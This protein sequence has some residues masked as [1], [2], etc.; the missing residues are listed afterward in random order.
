MPRSFDTPL[1]IDAVLEDLSRTLDQ[2]NAAVLVAPP[3]AG[4][5]TRVPLA[6][7]DARWAKGKKIIVLEPRRIA[8]RASADRMAKSL[9]E[10]AGETVGYRVRFGSKISRATRIEVVTEGI[11][12]RQILDDPELSGVAAILFDEFHE[13]SLD[14]DMG[15]A[16]AR[17]A[18]TGLREDLRILVMSATLDGA[19]VAKLLGD[20]PVVE[21]EGRAFPVETRYLGRKTDAPI[22]RQMADA[23]AS[24]LRADSGSV[25]A[26]LPGAA[27]IRRTQNFLSERVQDASIEIVPLFG[28][29]DAAVQDR[30]IA[31]APKGTRKVVLATSIAETSLTIEGVRIVVDSGLARVPRYE[32]DIGLTRLET[33]RA[34]RAAVDQR[35]GRAG[36][37]EPG[38]CYRLWD[39]PQTASLAPYTQPEILSADLSSLV[40]DLAQWGVTD[41]AALSFLDPPPQ[42]AWKEAKSLLSEL[43]ALD[44]DGRITAEGKSLRALAL[45]PRLA[46]MIVDSHRA[47]SGEA[48]AEIAAIITERGLGGDSVDLEHRRDQFRRDRSP[49][50]A[51]ARELARRWASQVA[52]SEKAGQR[53][54]DLSTGLMLAYAF[55]DR[56]ARNRGNGSFVLAN[57]RGA[58]VEQTSSLA[59]APYIAIGEMTGTAASGRILLAAQ[60]TQDEIEL[61]FAEHIESADEVSFDRGAMALRA[62]RRRALHAITLSEATLAVSPSEDTARIFADGLIAAGLDRLPWSKAAKQWRDR[63]MF[64]R[65]AEGDSWPDLSDDGLIARRD[66]WLVPALYDKIALKDISAGDLSDALMALLPWEMRARLDREAPT[67]FEAPTGSVLAIDYEAEQGPTIAVR[68]QELFGLNTHPS[69]AAGKV[70]LVLELLSPAQRPVQ[71]TRDLPGFWRGSYAAVRSDLRGRYPRHPWPDDPAT[72]LPTRRA[73]P[74]GT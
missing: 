5:T 58:A 29:L 1:P 70:P 51:S 21:S 69:I 40:L 3:G 34:A 20:A 42:P 12:T 71:V 14:A 54:D 68:L 63:V 72:A 59:R 74:R 64:L 23:I 39:E 55:P 28:A 4:K 32:P 52:A 33:V 48:A 62:R 47:G 22:E 67:H 15:L 35:R 36:R 50:A 9:G 2:H 57:G 8:A 6:L 56:V 10:R 41:P 30:A 24:A 38:I 53:D 44:G 17:D 25:L 7:L 31:P 49:R 45:P 11:F 65:K 60:I 13:R 19:R 66:D 37:T 18:Q 61:H 46:R 43:N 16:L 26:F 73:K 27:E